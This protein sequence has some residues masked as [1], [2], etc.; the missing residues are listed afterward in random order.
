MTAAA[1]PMAQALGLQH[2][3]LHGQGQGFGAL[4]PQLGD[5]PAAGAG[6]LDHGAVGLH[7]QDAGDEADEHGQDVLG[8]AS[9]F[10]MPSCS[11]GMTR[12]QAKQVPQA[13]DLRRWVGLAGLEP[14]T[15]RL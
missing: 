10:V 3:H 8:P 12:E 7:A 11:R 13:C 14:A 4:R 6:G 5:G 15:E 9:C 2:R 1:R